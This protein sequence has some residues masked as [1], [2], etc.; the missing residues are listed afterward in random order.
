MAWRWI[1]RGVC[2][3]VLVLCAGLWSLSYF[4]TAVIV[5]T[6]GPQ[7]YLA[8][9]VGIENGMIHVNRFSTLISS[10]RLLPGWNFRWQGATAASL[11]S[12][13]SLHLI[14]GD[15]LGFRLRYRTWFPGRFWNAAIPFWCP[16]TLLVL[17]ILIVWR[18]TARPR[19]GRGFP[20]VMQKG[21]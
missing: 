13:F 10:Y 14:D 4:C 8:E 5:E 21:V 3:I 11:R 1:I 16:T 9:S 6:S 20:V 2:L 17:L 12:P 7:W 15:F 18:K 19:P